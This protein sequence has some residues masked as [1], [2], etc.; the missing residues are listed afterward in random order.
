[1]KF[2]FSS[3]VK[4]KDHAIQVWQFLLMFNHKTDHARR[5]KVNFH[6]AIL[7]YHGHEIYMA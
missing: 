4:K 1:M 6:L 3:S 2:D 5:K 7:I